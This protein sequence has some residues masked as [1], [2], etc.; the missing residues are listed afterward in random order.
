MPEADNTQLLRLLSYNIQV[1]IQTRHFADYIMASWQH[2]LPNQK[3]LEN[4]HKISQLLKPYD[5]IALQEVDGGSLRSS[6]INQVE[7]LAN[8]AGFP[9]WYHQCNRNLGKIAQHSNGLL[10]KIPVHKIINH[11]LPGLIPGRGAIEAIIGE[12]DEKLHII[13]AH[14]SLSKRA[15]NQ[16]VKYLASV[17]TNPTNV[18][19]M[20]DLNCNSEQLLQQFSLNGI[21]LKSSEDDS[22]ENNNSPTFPS[23]QPSRQFDHILVSPSI[24]IVSQSVLQDPISDHL[25]VVLEVLLPGSILSTETNVNHYHPVRIS[26]ELLHN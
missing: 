2:L 24:K 15:R 6:Y 9:Y 11:K 26:N 5:L 13:N 4:L 20:G 16:Q 21:E 1:G 8:H 18:I 3:R 10:S 17:I 23:W 22:I 14:L 12:S 19:I 7:Y 25:P